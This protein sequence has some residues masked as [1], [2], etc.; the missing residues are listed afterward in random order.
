MHEHLIDKS[1]KDA[2]IL[3]ILA[4][5]TSEAFIQSK[6]NGAISLHSEISNIKS[7]LRLHSLIKEGTYYLNFIFEVNDSENYKILPYLLLE[8]V[9]NLLKYADLSHEGEPGRINIELENDILTMKT[10][11][12]KARQHPVTTHHFGMVNLKNRL[13]A[14]Y[15][16]NYNLSIEEDQ[17]TFTLILK[18]VL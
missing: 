5:I 4:D 11:N 8:P 1:P 9:I 16:T 2:E 18:I 17:Y 10:W 13:D 15:P 3:E 7:Y 12:R 14:Y 6:F